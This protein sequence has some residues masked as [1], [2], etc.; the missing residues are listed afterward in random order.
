MF[1]QIV[2]LAL[3]LQPWIIGQRLA[4][5]ERLCDPIGELVRGDVFRGEMIRVDLRFCLQRIAAVGE[6]CGLLGGGCT[7]ASGACEAGEPRQAL[8]AGSDIFAA[9]GV[10][11]WDQEA[12]H[13]C[14]FHRLAQEFEALGAV[15]RSG[16][17]V[18]VLKHGIPFDLDVSEFLRLLV[19][20][21]G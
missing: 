9:M 1:G 6:N 4:L 12:V 19:A 17:D 8:V 15:F 13:P 14:G 5:L 7:D 16:G 21:A 10:A 18:E 20:A 3:G 11:S 2:D